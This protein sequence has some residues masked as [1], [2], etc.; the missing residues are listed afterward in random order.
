MYTLASIGTAVPPPEQ[1]LHAILR[2]P[3]QHPQPEE[4]L[5]ESLQRVHTRQ[6]T[7]PLPWQVS[8]AVVPSR[9]LREACTQG[10]ADSAG[11]SEGLAGIRVGA[12]AQHKR[13][14]AASKSHIVSS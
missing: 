1:L 10:Y 7:T 11:V 8:H 12:C 9:S 13:L 3:A 4:S 6:S 5:V 2:L 14:I